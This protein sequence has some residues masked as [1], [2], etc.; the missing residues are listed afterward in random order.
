M[1]KTM[2]THAKA[3]DHERLKF[4][5]RCNLIQTSIREFGAI[6]L[7]CLQI[8]QPLKMYQCSIIDIHRSSKNKPFRTMATKSE[9]SGH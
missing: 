9:I 1:L 8:L 6:D 3:E 2:V 7:Q 4:G 5:Q